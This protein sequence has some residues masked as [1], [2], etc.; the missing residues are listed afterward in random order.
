MGKLIYIHN[1]FPHDLYFR[2]SQCFA[3]GMNLP[4]NICW[5]HE[6][7]IYKKEYAH[8]SPRQGFCR[9]A[10]NPPYAEDSDIALAKMIIAF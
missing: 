10:A 1:S 4:I 7:I 2:P 9:T 3:G 8:T 5:A 6:F